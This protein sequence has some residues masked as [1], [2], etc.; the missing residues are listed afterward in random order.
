MLE[1]GSFQL[2][3]CKVIKKDIKSLKRSNPTINLVESFENE[4]SSLKKAN[5][6][7]SPE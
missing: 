4:K 5:T 2:R 7:P 6:T 1:K 3:L